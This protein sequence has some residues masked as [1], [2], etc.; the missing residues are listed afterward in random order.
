M[1]SCIGWV[2][3]LS[4]FSAVNR[5]TI[6]YPLY[7]TTDN[8]LYEVAGSEPI[9]TFFRE[10]QITNLLNLR[11]DVDPLSISKFTHEDRDNLK[12][13]FVDFLKRKPPPLV[14]SNPRFAW[15]LIQWLYHLDLTVDRWVANYH[16]SDGLT[17]TAL[18]S[19]VNAMMPV[20]LKFS[21]QSLAQ[22]RSWTDIRLTL[23][24]NL[25]LHKAD[26]I[27]VDYTPNTTTAPGN[28]GDVA[29]WLY[30]R[31]WLLLVT[32]SRHRAVSL[33]EQLQGHLKVPGLGSKLVSIIDASG[34]SYKAMEEFRA[35]VKESWN[36][37][38]KQNEA[39]L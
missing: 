8:L 12:R 5:C 31:S 33:I 10:A 39:R 26:H 17:V 11:S 2:D 30:V 38:D 25:Y 32:D 9:F 22:R 21:G 6:N 4:T 24:R 3:G 14:S 19:E 20:R 37:H 13:V 18:W 1:T 15:Q 16:N 36:R 27:R 28:Y 7:T 34:D 23:L 35:L 29:E